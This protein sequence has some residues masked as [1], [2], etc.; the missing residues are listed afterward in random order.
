MTDNVADFVNVGDC[1]LAEEM[2]TG[3]SLAVLDLKVL[4]L[5]A[6]Y[7]S[8]RLRIFTEENL[9]NYFVKLYKIYIVFPN[10]RSDLNLEITKND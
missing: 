6:T 3:I 1:V 8:R 2:F 4:H 7:M 9:K 10:S 5:Q